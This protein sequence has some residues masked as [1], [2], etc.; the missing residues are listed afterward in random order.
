MAIGPEGGFAANVSEGLLASHPQLAEFW[1]FLDVLNGES[2]RGGVLVAA[3]F[4]EGLLYRILD[5]FMLDGKA[6]LQVLDGFNAPAGTFSAKIALAVALGLISERERRECEL[7]RKIRNKFAHNVHP[8]FDDEVIKA[9]CNELTF[10][11]MPYDGV[12]VNAKGSF[13]TAAVGL[14][15]NLTNR[16]HYVGLERIRRIDWQI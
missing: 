1:P 10:R 14:I 13:T 5:S 4:I 16:P 12:D 3:S 8:T 9:L 2:P 7:V 6:K 11:A 15:L